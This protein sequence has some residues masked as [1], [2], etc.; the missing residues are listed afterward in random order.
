MLSFLAKKHLPCNTFLEALGVGVGN[1][2]ALTDVAIVSAPSDA[3]RVQ[4]FKGAKK[5]AQRLSVVEW[6]LSISHVAKFAI[7]S[8]I[9]VGCKHTDESQAINEHELE[10]L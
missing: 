3:P 5:V 2:I 8:A 4:L 7:A 6:H 1:G 10:R 9:A